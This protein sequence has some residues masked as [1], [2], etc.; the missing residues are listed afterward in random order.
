MTLSL[1]MAASVTVVLICGGILGATV[2][3]AQPVPVASPTQWLCS[4]HLVSDP[5][6]LPSDTTDLGTGDVTPAHPLNETDKPVDCFYVYPTVSDQIALNAGLAAQPE[7]Q[8][9]ASYQAARFSSQ[10][11]VFAPIYRQMT[12]IPGI[13]AGSLGA[14]LA[15]LA[16][17][18]VLAAWNDYL[19]HDNNGRG[20]IFVGHSQGTM[21][22][23]KLIHDEI[24]PNSEL[25][26]QLVGAF[27]MGGN[28]L[29]AR[30][31]T[32]GG[33]F[34]SVPLCTNRGEIGCV[35]AY[36]TAGSD[37]LLSLFGNSSID[38]LS[39]QLGLRTGPAYEVACTDPGPLSGNNGPVGFTIPSSPF[40]F[41]IISILLGY[42]SFPDGAPTSASTWTT[43]AERA[44]GACAEVNRYRMYRFHSTTPGQ[45][46]NELPLL[47]THLVD[48]NLGYDRL[49][50]IADQQIQTYLA[51]N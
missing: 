5:C 12:L 4:P 50:S 14:P 3:A 42:T 39:A 21:M 29:T 41:G 27:L 38:L 25:R 36:S 44:V 1:R 40:A 26:G 7:I 32:V 31:S 49:V 16:Y 13:V 51:G 6:D 43:S 48:M 9:I 28:V 19:A 30:N 2:A 37:P 35:V 45:Q 17:S 20:V 10:C 33:D 46:V 24:D 23:R 22:L 18:D 11:R 34:E 47:S 8:S 15:P